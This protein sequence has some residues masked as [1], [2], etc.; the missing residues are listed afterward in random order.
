[1]IIHR[2]ARRFILRRGSLTGC[3]VNKGFEGSGL[4]LESGTVDPDVERRVQ[5]GPP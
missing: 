3:V 1:M 4:R 5:G 2:I